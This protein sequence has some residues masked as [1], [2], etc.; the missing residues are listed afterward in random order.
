MET[1]QRNGIRKISISLKYFHFFAI[2]FPFCSIAVCWTIYYSM[3]HNT[4]SYLP[5]ISVTMVPFPE[6]R[7]FAVTMSIESIF[8]LIILLCRVYSI[9]LSIIRREGALT[10]M[11]WFMI[12]MT[13]FTGVTSYIGLIL[14]SCFS[15]EDDFYIHNYSALVFFFGSFIHY[16][17]SDSTMDRAKISISLLSSA[18]SVLILIVMIVYLVLMNIKSL[19][20]A[21]ILQYITCALIFIKLYLIYLDLPAQY[22][23][24]SSNEYYQTEEQDGVRELILTDIA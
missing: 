6:S 13:L 2:I 23:T 11:Q 8:L 18:N 3:S 12:C 7:I 9:Y 14:L 20:F 16:V 24:I 10:K 5:T 22:F 1:L 4:T 17:I 15:L 21:A 19:T